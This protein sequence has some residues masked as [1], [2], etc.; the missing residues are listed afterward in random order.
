MANALPLL[1]AAGAAAVLLGKKKKKSAKVEPPTPPVEPPA[2][3]DELPLPGSGLP[4][5]GSSLTP[6]A[7]PV[8]GK[9]VA[10][11]VER[12]YTG[13]YSWKII[14]DPQGTGK[15]YS[16][17]YYSMGNLGPHEEVARGATIEEAIKE[18]QFWATNEDRRK[19]NLPPLLKTGV[20]KSEPA[21]TGFADKDTSGDL[22]G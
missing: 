10:N 16:A 5:G 2:P 13:A 22:G 21:K 14:F 17:H 15:D 8:P 9:A 18:F 7:G 12:H 4:P 1:L 11:G 3:P 19:R 20:L 6:G